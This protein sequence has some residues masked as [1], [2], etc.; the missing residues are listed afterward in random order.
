MLGP[1]TICMYVRMCVCMYGVLAIRYAQCVL[2]EGNV[3]IT[4]AMFVS[5]EIFDPTAMQ[6]CIILCVYVYNI[7]VWVCVSQI[8]QFKQQCVVCLCKCVYL[9][10]PINNIGCVSTSRTVPVAE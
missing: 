1:T 8:D 10:M 3:V 7:C 6:L 2:W 5:C 9:E 4:V